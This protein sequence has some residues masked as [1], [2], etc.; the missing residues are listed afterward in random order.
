[1]DQLEDKKQISNNNNDNKKEIKNYNEDEKGL[2]SELNDFDSSFFNRNITNKAIQIAFD[3]I[4]KNKLNEYIEK[5]GTL[6][7]YYQTPLNILISDEDEKT[8]EMISIVLKKGADPNLPSIWKDTNEKTYPLDIA[9]RKGKHNIVQTLVNYGARLENIDI[10]ECLCRA[11]LEKSYDCVEFAISNG[12]KIDKKVIIMMIDRYETSNCIQ[13]NRIF[14]LFL[15]TNPFLENLII[16][17]KN[18][19]FKQWIENNH[20]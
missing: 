13:F 2:K 8:F 11:A 5:F 20:K 9:F 6:N 12:A 1:M 17:S 7:R 4:N 3:A 15:K 16:N 18:T 10:S 14:Q 19:S